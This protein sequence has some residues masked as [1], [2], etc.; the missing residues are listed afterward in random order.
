MYVRQNF[1]KK[2]LFLL[3]L[4][5]SQVTLFAATINNPFSRERR[6]HE[7]DVG[8]DSPISLESYSAIRD[9]F[10]KKIHYGAP[11]KQAR[12]MIKCDNVLDQ[13]RL[14]LGNDGKFC[15]GFFSC[16]LTEVGE[17]LSDKANEIVAD[18]IG[19]R[20]YHDGL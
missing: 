3:G 15:G 16:R 7:F 19:H 18:C 4:L 20:H 14:R 6:Q 10:M 2:F 8:C 9:C 5:L 13:T 17:G 12:P 11:D 1:S